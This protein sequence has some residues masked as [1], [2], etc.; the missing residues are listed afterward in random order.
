MQE[1]VLVAGKSREGVLTY[2]L[3]T[4]TKLIFRV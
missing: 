3:L 1:Q 4:V 2:A